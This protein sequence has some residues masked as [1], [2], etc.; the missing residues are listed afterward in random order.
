MRRGTDIQHLGRSGEDLPASNATYRGMHKRPWRMVGRGPALPKALDSREPTSRAIW[1]RS[2][3]AAA[4]FFSAASLGNRN[5]T[6]IQP[7]SSVAAY[8]P[9]IPR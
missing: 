5:P 6:T 1:A 8:V 3:A 9:P 2:V 7:F 4:R